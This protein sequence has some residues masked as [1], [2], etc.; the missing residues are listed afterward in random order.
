MLDISNNNEYI[1]TSSFT[2]NNNIQTNQ[3]TSTSSSPSKTNDIQLP[4][5]QLNTKTNYTDVITSIIIGAI[6]DAI[7]LIVGIFL[8]YKWYKNKKEQ[9][10]ATLPNNVT[11]PNNMT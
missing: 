1:W 10:N 8:L 2:L 4:N 9:N 6:I 3:P 7:L 11:L 5:S